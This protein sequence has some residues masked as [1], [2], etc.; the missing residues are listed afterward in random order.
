[1]SRSPSTVSKSST[2][3]KSKNNSDDISLK[4]IMSSL[5]SIYSEIQS[6]KSKLLIQENTSTVILSK[7]ESL[8]A[9]ISLLKKE[10]IELKKVLDI[11]RS[12]SCNHSLTSSFDQPNIGRF[13]LRTKGT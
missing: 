10:N 4:D 6:V 13:S 9:D 3:L 7:L 1:M 5:K 11:L 2:N 12:I 8:A